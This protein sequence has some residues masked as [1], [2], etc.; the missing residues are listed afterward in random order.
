M[1]HHNLLNHINHSSDSVLAPENGCAA[2][3]INVKKYESIRNFLQ[4]HYI[5]NYD[6]IFNE[7]LQDNVGFVKKRNL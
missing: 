6:W 7:L 1:N 5:E 2:V 4:A 3:G